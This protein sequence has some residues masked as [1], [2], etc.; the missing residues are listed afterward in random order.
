MSESKTPRAGEIA[1]DFSLPDST[2]AIVTLTELTADAPC[3][4]VFYRGHW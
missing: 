3:A 2:G 1:P 4:I